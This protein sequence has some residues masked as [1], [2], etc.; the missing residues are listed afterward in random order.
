MIYNKS[1]LSC[2]NI[3][4]DSWYHVVKFL[5]TGN[6]DYSVSTRKATFAADIQNIQLRINTTTD[7]IFESNEIIEVVAL[8]PEDQGSYCRARVIIVDDS[9]LLS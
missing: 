8:L 4:N 9:K 6:T 3:I 2:I 7:S 1:S 5:V